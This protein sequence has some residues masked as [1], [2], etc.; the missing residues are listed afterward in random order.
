MASWYSSAFPGVDEFGPQV[1]CVVL[2]TAAILFGEGIYAEFLFWQLKGQIS[3]LYGAL[4][5]INIWAMACVFPFILLNGVSPV[6]PFK[7][8][9]QENDYDADFPAVYVEH[10]IIFFFP[11][12]AVANCVRIVYDYY[13]QDSPTK[14]YENA[15]KF[16]PIAWFSQA[17]VHVLL[18]CGVMDF[19]M[20][21]MIIFILDYIQ[22]LAGL[23]YWCTSGKSSES[24]TKWCMSAAVCHMIG[25]APIFLY[26]GASRSYVEHDHIAHI[27]VITGALVLIAYSQY[28]FIQ[29]AVET[30]KE[31]LD[32]R[33]L[34]GSGTDQPLK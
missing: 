2:A 16:I 10:Y 31:T 25:I 33:D 24:R 13:G 28:G 12:C 21:I 6:P 4:I 34:T 32:A 3:K 15:W 30:P 23:V 7:G 14:G 26:R 27:G 18:V 17:W 29:V 20:G 5:S 19:G 22:H 8:E 1:T 9:G 11:L